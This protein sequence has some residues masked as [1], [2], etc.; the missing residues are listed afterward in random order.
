MFEPIV[1]LFALGILAWLAIFFILAVAIILA[2][3]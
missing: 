1:A 2:E 3:F